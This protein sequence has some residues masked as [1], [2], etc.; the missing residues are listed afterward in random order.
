MKKAVR[1]NN[2]YYLGVL[3]VVSGSLF[4]LGLGATAFMILQNPEEVNL[5]RVIMA[6][7][8][9]TAPLLNGRVG[10]QEFVLEAASSVKYVFFSFVGLFLVSMMISIA[11]GMVA[12]GIRV[13][14]YAAGDQQETEGDNGPVR[15][16]EG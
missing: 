8:E 12:S 14:K 4:L 6:S 16:F 5:A 13:A 1:N 2:L 9:S 11:N 15:G 3:L 7:F 10:N